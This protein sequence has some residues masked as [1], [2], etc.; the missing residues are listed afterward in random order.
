MD[1]YFKQIQEVQDARL[2]GR[3][4]TLEELAHAAGAAADVTNSLNNMITSII[5]A[6]KITS[7]RN[8]ADASSAIM[9]M[10]ISVGVAFTLSIILGIFVTKGITTPLQGFMNALSEVAKG[11]FTVKADV[12][13][14]DEVGMLGN[15]LNATLLSLRG[16]IKKVSDAVMVVSSGATELSASAEQ[17]SA[18]TNEIA[19]SE[20]MLHQVTDSVASATVEF[21]ASVEEVANNVKVS[22]DHANESVAQAKIG[23]E[24]AKTT[25]EGMNLIHAFSKKIAE[26]VK[27][28]Q[29]LATQTNLLSLNAAIEAAKAGEQGK[30][31]AVVAEEVRK[32]A[33]RSATAAKE[34]EKIIHDTQSA[35]SNGVASVDNI[36][37][38]I[39]KMEVSIT[40]VAK[41]VNEIGGATREQTHAAGEIS[42]HMEESARELGQN[43]AA[44]QEM[45]A[46]VHEI[47]R[48]ASDLARVAS[49]LV[50]A[51][52]Q[53]TV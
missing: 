3:N 20:E 2:A 7:E 42:K 27:V 24:D 38:A 6:A 23:S 51:M 9:F 43:A 39:K 28:I 30:G 40:K 44:T 14:K 32:L 1:T 52:S 13:S 8:A 41:V 17:M 53:F 19:K 45:S 49:D 16:S 36:T 46:T 21:M 47:S 50:A 37:G 34:I 4:F 35:V 29:E 11:N 12:K 33:E 15:S 22:V 18:T 31:F 25:T 48:T 26:A 10:S 5:A